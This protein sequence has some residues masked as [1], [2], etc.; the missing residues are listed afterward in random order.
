MAELA[1]S[2]QRELN[3]HGQDDQPHEARNRVSR[4]SVASPRT[5]GNARDYHFRYNA[6][7][8]GKPSG[9]LTI[10]AESLYPKGFSSFWK[11]S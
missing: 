1:Q 5:V 4:K 7:S 6:T 2:S 3:P 9:Q 8:P 11:N 10:S